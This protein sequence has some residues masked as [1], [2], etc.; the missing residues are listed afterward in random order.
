MNDAL[1]TGPD[2]QEALSRVYAR[3][4]AARA[5]YTTADHDFDRDG[6]DLRIQAGGAMRPAL[7]LQLKATTNLGQRRGRYYH[8]PLKVRNYDCLREDTQTPRILVV[9]ALPKNQD[10]WMTITE[11]E[12]VLR[13]QAF[14]LNLRGSEET[15][16]RSTT[17]VKIPC[18]NRFH[19]ESLHVLMQQ[20]REGK[21]P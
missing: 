3:A 4:V 6:I 10:Q 16:N 12:L 15:T 17:T 11:E 13:G 8:F 14:W 2:Q 19:A 18:K 9:L 20:S 5:G 21:I 1:L 7:E